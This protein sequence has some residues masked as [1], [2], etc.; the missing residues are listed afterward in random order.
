M[1]RASTTRPVTGRSLLPALAAVLLAILLPAQAPT[2]ASAA[3]VTAAPAAAAAVATL[4]PATDACLRTASSDPGGVLVFLDTRIS[5][6]EAT[7]LLTALRKMG[8]PACSHQVARQ[9]AAKAYAWW[10]TLPEA[11]RPDTVVLGVWGNAAQ[12]ARWQELRPFRRLI[13]T[14]DSGVD[15]RNRIGGW[16]I[17]AT[18]STAGRAIL[19]RLGEFMLNVH[20]WAGAKPS[21]LITSSAAQCAAAVASPRGVLVLGDSITSHDVPG[22]AAAFRAR[23]LVPCIYAQSGS[24]LYEHLGRLATG[25][26]PMPANVMVLLGNNDIFTGKGGYPF[27]FRAQALAMVRHLR[28]H[29]I[30]WPTVWRTRNQSFRLPLQHNCWA[31]NNVVRDLSRDIP[32]M[33]VPDWAAVVRKHPRLQFDGIHLTPAGLSLRYTMLADALVAMLPPA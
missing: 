8:R 24:R 19:L 1:T 22:M 29:T 6:Y 7:R 14:F 5:A 20:A 31:V 18:G 11:R 13:G 26:V 15:A 23:G 30:V 25:H 4:D 27:R 12:V 33:R 10:S 28:G 2:P 32:T 9:T 16:P 3:A 17:G 21:Q